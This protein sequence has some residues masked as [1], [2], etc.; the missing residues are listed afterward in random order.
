[1]VRPAAPAAVKM[2][3]GITERLFTDVQALDVS[4]LQLEGDVKF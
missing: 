1:M 3:L 4:M 2:P